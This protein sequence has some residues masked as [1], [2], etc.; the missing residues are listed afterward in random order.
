MAK[1]GTAYVEIKPDLSGFARELKDR[2]KTID[3]DYK[4]DVRP[5][6]SGFSKELKAELKDKNAPKVKIKVE[7]DFT[8]FKEE[9]W[10]RIKTMKMPVLKI[11]VEADTSQIRGALRGLGGGRGGG[12]NAGGALANDLTDGFLKGIQSLVRQIPGVG[13]A[14]AGALANPAGVVMVLV[15]AAGLA[16]AAEFAT[17]LVGGLIG[18]LGGLSLIGLGIF[19]Q[20]DDKGIRKKAKEFGA[21]LKKELVAATSGFKLPIMAS[22]DILGKS[23]GEALKILKPAFDAIGPVLPELSK[24]LGEMMTNIATAM[25]KPENV[26]AMKEFLLV[27]AQTLP[28]IG[29]AIGAIFDAMGENK[30]TIAGVLRVSLEAIAGFFTLIADMIRG[31]SGDLVEIR[32]GWKAFGDWVTAQV[33]KI[34]ASFATT[35]QQ[36]RTGT[37]AVFNA[38]KNT[39]VGAWNAV[40]NF[41]TSAW[42][43]VKNSVI[44]AINGVKS[45]V[46]AGINAVVNWFSGLKS[47]ISNSLGA[48]GSLLW[49]VG[50][51]IVLGL[52]RGIQDG[53]HWVTDKIAELVNRIPEPVRKLLGINSP[54][55]VFAEIGKSIP[56]GLA[57]G[58]S[59]GG[60]AVNNAAS[61]LF[62]RIPSIG[63]TA[64]AAT[65]GLGS[66]N[67]GPPQIRVFIG[68][69]ELTDI[70]RTEVDDVNLDTAR[71]LVSGR[72]Q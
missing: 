26:E 46:S 68:E 70:V 63:T 12:G 64:F 3:V 15:A 19:G 23:L 29:N 43:F 38:I 67:A 1:V 42:N 31:A 14:I 32:E 71:A 13:P 39:V 58:I 8:G 36:L 40:K 28:D 41:T 34:K 11:K 44:G 6:L 25:A 57:L 65:S 52:A 61:D 54:S 7:P 60:N 10:A 56:E 66:T 18:L 24:G 50:S 62:G 27:L 51:D 17:A 21:T 2:L 48:V 16:V 30:D 53:W 20:K 49:S 59:S 33:N 72:R 47:R 45:T 37:T 55:K 22:L 69:R 4:V 5:D 35:W 9:V